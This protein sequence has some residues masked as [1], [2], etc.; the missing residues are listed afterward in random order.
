LKA[1]TDK[2]A[3]TNS[4]PV[5]ISSLGPV[6]DQ[7]AKQAR[8]RGTQK[9]QEDDCRIH[10]QPFIRLTSSTAMVPRLRK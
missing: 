3:E 6:A 7:A 4:R 8:D 2:A 1:S 10:L 5:V 9:R